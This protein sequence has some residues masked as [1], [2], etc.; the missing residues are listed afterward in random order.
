MINLKLSRRTLGSVLTLLSLMVAM[1]AFTPLRYAQFTGDDWHYLVLLANISSWQPIYTDNLILTY[2]Y[3][4][5]ALTL[6][7]A[8]VAAFDA[9]PL[10]HYAVNV[11]L[12]GMT[13]V[14]VC[15]LVF[16]DSLKERWPHPQKLLFL[17]AFTCP[18]AAT[19]V[20]WI[21]NRFDLCSTLFSICAIASLCQ[22][23]WRRSTNNLSAAL[24]LLWLSI[25]L[26]CKET[27]FACIPALLV[28]LCLSKRQALFSRGVVAL[29][30]VV[31]AVAWLVARRLALGGW[32]GGA[33]L[34]LT[35]DTLVRGL[36]HWIAG[37]SAFTL[38]EKWWLAACITTVVVAMVAA[39]FR[40]ER[41]A[42]VKLMA[43]I[44][45]ATGTVVLQAPIMATALDAV[46]ETMPA[47]SY[48][49][50]YTP[51][52]CL[53]AV[54]GLVVLSQRLRHTVRL[55]RIAPWAAACV[56]PWSAYL[57]HASADDWSRRTA[58]ELAAF[59]ALRPSIDEKL[60]RSTHA[61]PC[62][63]DL[64]T[65]PANAAGIPVDLMY[66]AGRLRSDPV[67]RCVLV[68]EPPQSMSITVGSLCS[69]DVTP[70]WRNDLAVIRPA[71][72]AGTCTFFYL[73]RD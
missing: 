9:T 12:H 62:L 20:F 69:Y 16:G 46:G 34:A 4:P 31:A 6:F 11:F 48:R 44:T 73:K 67:L 35:Y 43:I 29:A 7:A 59:E 66:K 25:A 47:V 57:V 54:I 64:G 68:S 17:V 49:F 39:R 21:S 2:L 55:K 70:G 18:V 72:R 45:Y 65:L 30:T 58:S 63:V 8:S 19:T 24:T 1:W 61:P 52:V 42:T 56:L 10:P 41:R 37:F 5:V 13:A 27:A 28:V 53:I 32:D 3:R 22:W 15:C 33:S 14:V 40:I 71:P 38:G 36:V 60:V 26:G 23:S 50:Y 51:V